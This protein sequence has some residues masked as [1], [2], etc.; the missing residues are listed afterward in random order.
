MRKILTLSV[1]IFSTFSIASSDKWPEFNLEFANVAIVAGTVV[2]AKYLPDEEDPR[3]KSGELI[4]MD[5]PPIKLDIE[6][7]Q[8]VSGDI[9]K[10]TISVF[11]TS[12]YGIDHFDVDGNAY[13][14][15]LFTDGADFILPRYHFKLLSY[16]SN[17]AMSLPMLHKTDLPYWLPCEVN[18]LSKEIDFDPSIG[19]ILMPIEE[20]E[21]SDLIKFKGFSH[22]SKYAIRALR[23]VE[24][25]DLSRYFSKNN[26]SIYNYECSKSVN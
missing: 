22:I 3:C 18:S 9:S 19:D 6:I 17:D 8:L 7:E 11:T 16:S 5:P 23:G 25:K 10:K 15:L 4:C 14:F 2:K 1:I 20:F 12:H 24:L 13:L 26:I 21:E